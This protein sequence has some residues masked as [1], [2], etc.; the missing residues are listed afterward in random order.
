MILNI[1]HSSPYFIGGEDSKG[2]ANLSSSPSQHRE[3]K[4]SGYDKLMLSLSSTQWIMRV[5]NQKQV[6]IEEGKICDIPILWQKPLKQEEGIANDMMDE[7]H[8][9]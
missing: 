7:L 4:S 5:I 2:A 3:K 9:S 1:L 8:R 6:G